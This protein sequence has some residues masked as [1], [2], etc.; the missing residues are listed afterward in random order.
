MVEEKDIMPLAY[1]AKE[2]FSGSDA[3]MRYRIE[4]VTEVNEKGK[5]KAVGLRVIAWPQPFCYESTPEEQKCSMETSYTEEGRQEILT[6]LREQ[7][8]MNEE[9]Y[10]E[11]ARKNGL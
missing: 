3:G 1:F 8:T 4:A 10:R 6:W 7:Y 11:A 2:E 9:M 5:K